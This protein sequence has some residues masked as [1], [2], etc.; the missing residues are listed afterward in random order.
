MDFSVGRGE[1]F[2]FWDHRRGKKHAAENFDR[3]VPD[4][5]GSVVVNGTECEHRDRR[6]MRTLGSTFEFSTM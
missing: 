4:Y 3:N 6:F 1:I 2:G 5:Q